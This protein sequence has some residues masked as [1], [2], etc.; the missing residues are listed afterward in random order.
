[1]LEVAYTG[2]SQP[3]E[4]VRVTPSGKIHLAPTGPVEIAGLTLTDAQVRLRELLSRFYADTRISVDLVEVRRFR[5]HLLGHVE[6]P[7]AFEVSAAHRASDLASLQEPRDRASARNMILRRDSLEIPVDLVRYRL[8]GDLSANPML[9]D[10]DVLY[11]PA[12]RDS[13]S[14]FGRVARPGFFEFREEDSIDDLI[15]FAGGFDSGADTEAVELRRFEVSDSRG[16]SAPDR[17]RV[18]G[19]KGASRPCRATG[20]TYVRIRT[21]AGRGSC[22]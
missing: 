22:S 13:V 8:L 21:G 10:G 18:S 1:M 9:Q 20:S 12:R 15:A 16:D 7:G 4:R 11:V 6:T 14:V 3:S 2:G 5:V 17:R 19:A